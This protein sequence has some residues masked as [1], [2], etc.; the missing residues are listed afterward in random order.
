MPFVDTLSETN[1]DSE[2]AVS[3]LGRLAIFGAPMDMLSP[4]PKEL[5]LIEW[6]PE[7]TATNK[8]SSDAER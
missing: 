6:Q 1:A 5:P 2:D 8:S 7:K 4:N 3:R